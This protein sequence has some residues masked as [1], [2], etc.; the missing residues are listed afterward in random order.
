[1]DNKTV[2]KISGYGTPKLAF[3][4]RA[5]EGLMDPRVTDSVAY[6]SEG[7]SSL[8]DVSVTA[9]FNVFN[10]T[11]ASGAGSCGFVTAAHCGLFTCLP[12]IRFA[13]DGCWPLAGYTLTSYIK[14]KNN[15][16]LFGKVMVI[17]KI[18]IDIMI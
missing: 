13:A 11:L 3:E 6:V 1:V 5:W 4:M 7:V 12:A 16:T 9:Q 17:Q 10:R 15:F 14:V 18:Y 2:P 8:I